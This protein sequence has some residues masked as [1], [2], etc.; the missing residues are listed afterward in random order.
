MKTIITKSDPPKSYLQTAIDNEECGVY[1]VSEMSNDFIIILAAD[2]GESEDGVI[3]LYYTP[4][5]GYSIV[6]D[7][8]AD[9]PIIKTNDTLTLSN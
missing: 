5:A 1:R 9:R 8:W 4:S 7:T 6:D 2:S 3:V